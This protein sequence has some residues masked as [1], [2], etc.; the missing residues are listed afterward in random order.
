MKNAYDDIRSLIDREPSW[1]DEHG[2]PR[3]CEF[4]PDESA[5]IYAET[6][7]LVLVSCQACGHE[8]EVCFSQDRYALVGENH[9]LPLSDLIETHALH[10]GDPPNACC[11]VGST[12]NS[13]PRRV[14]QFWQRNHAKWR[15]PDE[16]WERKPEHEIEI[17]PDWWTKRDADFDVSTLLGEL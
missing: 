5:N 13:V 4:A 8:F 6:V 9:D 12:M 10:Y 7:C 15:T 11:G 14:L 2:V 1:F 16:A 3:Y 17:E